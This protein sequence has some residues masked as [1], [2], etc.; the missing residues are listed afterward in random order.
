[1]IALQPPAPVISGEVDWQHNRV[2]ISV[3]W[4]L[5]GG[6]AQRP[7]TELRGLL[8]SEALRKLS[9]ITERLW[10][11]AAARLEQKES[12]DFAQFYSQL[13]LANFQ[14]A[15]N[16]ASAML[17]IALRGR[18]SL[19][20]FFPL[21]FGSELATDTAHDE[22]AYAQRANTTEYDTS[23][24]EPIR[25]TGVIIDARHLPFTPSLN[26]AIFTSSGRQFYGAEFLRRITAVRRGV[27]GF[28]PAETL[29]EVLRRAGKRPLKI[30]ALGL[31][32]AGTDLIISEEDAARLL[33]HPDSRR[34]LERARVVVLVPTEKLSEKF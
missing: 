15:E 31:H 16:R 21:P 25:Y 14:V 13:K 34:N 8:R 6:L 27:M 9:V 10:Q 32:N 20:S 18:D 7:N 33:A 29:P 5:R 22:S 26:S 11:K 24:A 3:E 12:P 4:Q 23:D 17:Q 1:M 19:L 30:P 28:Y 2:M